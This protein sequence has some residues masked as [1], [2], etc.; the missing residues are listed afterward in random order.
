MKRLTE[1][2]NDNLI[3]QQVLADELYRFPMT[4]AEKKKFFPQLEKKT[5]GYSEIPTT[6]SS[7]NNT[8]LHTNTTPRYTLIEIIMFVC[9][10][11]IIVVSEL[12]RR[13]QQQRNNDLLQLVFQLLRK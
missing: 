7:P 3:Y 6:N 9:L 10:V 2:D 4:E 1:S 13:Y 5:E 11:I 8:Y 12:D